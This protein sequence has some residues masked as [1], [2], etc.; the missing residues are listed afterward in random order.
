MNMSLKTLYESY[1]ESTKYPLAWLWSQINVKPSKTNTSF[2]NTTEMISAANELRQR[3]VLVPASVLSNLSTAI[4]QR[5]VAMRS[6]QG[7]SPET[8]ASHEA[9]IE[10]YDPKHR[11]RHCRADLSDWSK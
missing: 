11:D 4:K 7:T 1:K 2:A 9:F 6:F 10:R 5:K 8:N 3:G